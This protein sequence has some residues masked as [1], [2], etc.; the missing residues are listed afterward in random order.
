M[1]SI[2]YPNVYVLCRFSPVK[3]W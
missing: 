2:V 3:P 1:N